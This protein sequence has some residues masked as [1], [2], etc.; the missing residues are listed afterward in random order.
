MKKLIL[1]LF[2]FTMGFIIIYKKDNQELLIPNNAIRFRIIA[3]SNNFSDQQLKIKI[4]E[5]IFNYMINNNYQNM[6]RNDLINTLKESNNLNQIINKY[7]NDYTIN[8]GL[9][10]FPEK[11][12]NG[13]IYP[14]GNYES[15]VITLGKGAGDNWW[16]L[17]YPPLCFVDEDSSNYKSLVKE[18][19]NKI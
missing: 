5:D 1:F 15:L 4:K 7:T 18:I 2:V 11:S 6:S 10:Y 16:C 14:G 19:I 8:Y 17:L 13:V 3:N 9:N 12:Y